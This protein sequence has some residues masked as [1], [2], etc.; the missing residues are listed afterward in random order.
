MT[1]ANF[2]HV[3]VVGLGYIGLPTAAV[4]ARA[5]HTV[6]GVDVSPTIVDKVNAG[7]IH[8]EE[9]DLDWLVRDMVGVGRLTASVEIKPSQF[10]VVAVPTPLGPDCQPDVEFVEAAVRAIAPTLNKGCCVIIESTSPV[11]TTERAGE[12]FAQ[13]R[14]DLRIP[15]I[16]SEEPADIAL[17][18]CPERVLPGRIIVELVANDR[19]IGG[20][21]PACAEQARGFY[22]SFVEGDCIPTTARTAEAVKLVENS[23]RDV[24]I[25]FANELSMIAEVVGF[26]VWDVIRLANRHPRVDI[27]QPG[28]GV[29]G[30]C[31]AVDPWFL[32]AS[33]PEQARLIR[34]A[35]QVNDFK[36][37]H[38]AARLREAAQSD[39]AKRIALLGLAFKPN[40]DDLRE[41][42]A[43]EIATE[44]AREFGD[45]IICVEPFIEVLPASLAD[46]GANLASAEDAL[47][48]ADTVA[49][50]VDHAQFKALPRGLFDHKAV[51]DTRGMLQA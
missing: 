49:I 13:L 41:S 36:A 28:P 20:M 21:T 35:R 5:G 42:P 45:R 30:H 50:L 27:L 8:I 14:P 7:G 38:V 10:Y 3:T 46:T 43:L 29:G 19:V 31:I 4:L 32:V 37:E 40:V 9:V 39:P 11:G 12:L 25:A 22:E 33:A 23:F 26:D 34:T 48:G 18:Y 15:R 44:L 51:F 17:A 1:G 16:G 24:N 6:C 2:S 47:A